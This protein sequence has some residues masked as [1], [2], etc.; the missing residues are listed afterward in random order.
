[1]LARL[2]SAKQVVA[3]LTTPGLYLFYR[4][5]V[6]RRRSIEFRS[7]PE[8]QETRFPI[9]ALIDADAFSQAPLIGPGNKVWPIQ[10]SFPQPAQ[11]KGWQKQFGAVVMGMPVWNMKELMMG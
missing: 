6:Y 9:W 11:W 5:K 1:M 3:L 7:F 2:L 10:A 8:R 4:G